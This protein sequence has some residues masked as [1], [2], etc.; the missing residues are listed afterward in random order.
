MPGHGISRRSD[1]I[2]L[3]GFMGAGKSTVGRLLARRLGLP[4]TDLDQL[5]VSLSGR[6]IPEIFVADGEARF[7]EL[8]RDAILWAVSTDHGGVIATG[9]GA[10]TAPENRSTMRRG[11]VVIHLSLPFELL[12][13]R[14]ASD[15]SRPLVK[16]GEEEVRS[17]FV[18]RGEAYRDADLIIDCAGKSPLEI[19]DEI[20]SALG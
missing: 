3:T 18:A 4:F 5:I 7:R 1:R 16:R 6:S 14:I 9:G 17:L 2:F 10:V 20:V 15:H 13:E 12:W 8:E 11:G 19:V